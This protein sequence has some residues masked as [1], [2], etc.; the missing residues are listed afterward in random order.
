MQEERSV[1]NRQSGVSLVELL[2][3]MVIVAILGA[4]A[5]PSYRAYMIRANRSDAKTAL[6]FYAGALERCYTRYNSYAYN[7]D[8]NVGCS[9]DFPVISDNGYYQISVTDA[10]G[11]RSASAFTL[12]AVPQGGQAGDTGCGKLTLDQLST[13]GKSG[14]KTVAECWGR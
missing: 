6:M 7:A 4:I 13:R 2:T 5:V 11:S 12:V 3:V 9:V 1:R 10:L 8:P 14:S